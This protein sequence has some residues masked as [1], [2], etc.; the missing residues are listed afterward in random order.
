MY[1]C[2]FTESSLANV[3]V[4]YL[5]VRRWH[6]YWYYHGDVDTT[7]ILK[8]LKPF[9]GIVFNFIG[10]SIKKKIFNFSKAVGMFG[11]QIGPKI[12]NLITD[13]I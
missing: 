11:V 12:S 2:S 3:Y 8:T 5:Q 4:Y 9:K 7:M 10:I 1:Y 6:Y 13:I